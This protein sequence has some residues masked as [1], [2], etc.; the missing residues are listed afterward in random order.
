[1]PTADQL[2]A[3]QSG[4]TFTTADGRVVRF[5]RF[6]AGKATCVDVESGERVNLFPDRSTPPASDVGARTE[7]E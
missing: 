5:V 3:L 6:R 1:M 2:R 4:D 7:Q